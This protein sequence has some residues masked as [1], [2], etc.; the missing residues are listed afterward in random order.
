MLVPVG[1]QEIQGQK[2]L[3]L[4]RKLAKVE[5]VF[6][7]DKGTPHLGMAASK[8]WMHENCRAL[9]TIVSKTQ[10]L[11]LSRVPWVKGLAFVT[12]FRRTDL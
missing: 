4:S 7:L 3:A 12:S 9:W 6:E 2:V 1:D 5:V 8:A 10:G 11:V